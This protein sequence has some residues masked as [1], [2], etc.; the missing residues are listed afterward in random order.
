[1]G[2]WLSV[3][4]KVMIVRP[5]SVR[6]PCTVRV[7]GVLSISNSALSRSPASAVPTGFEG[8]SDATIFTKYVPSGTVVVSQTRIGSERLRRSGF[9]VVSPSR[10]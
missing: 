2:E 8:A 5:L 10:R 7:G 1:M 3:T 6:T 9:H 4:S